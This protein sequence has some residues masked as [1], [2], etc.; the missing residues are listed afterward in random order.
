MK[1]KNLDGHGLLFRNELDQ[2]E[3]LKKITIHNSPTK[4]I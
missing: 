2:T 3:I 1:K 4:V